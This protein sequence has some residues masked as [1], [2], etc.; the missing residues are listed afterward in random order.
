MHFPNQIMFEAWQHGAKQ[1]RRS[2]C[3]DR[4]TTH[5]MQ[6]AGIENDHAAGTKTLLGFN[7][8]LIHTP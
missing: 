5:N 6:P 3:D 7:R 8:D 4:P 1:I 2:V